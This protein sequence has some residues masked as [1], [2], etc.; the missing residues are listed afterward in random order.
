M[1]DKEKPSNLGRKSGEQPGNPVILPCPT[2]KTTKT[3]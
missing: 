2:G 3:H 1:T